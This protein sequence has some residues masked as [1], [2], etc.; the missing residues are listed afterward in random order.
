[1]KNIQRFKLP[2]MIA[3]GLHG[4]LLFS[5]PP[6]PIA[7]VT[8]APPTPVLPPIPKILEMTQPDPA[9]ADAGSGGAGEPVASLPEPVAKLPDQA[10]ITIPSVTRDPLKTLRPDMNTLPRNIGTEGAPWGDPGDGIGK[11]PIFDT[12]SL[13]RTPRAIAQPSPDYPAGLRHEGVTGTVTVEFV[14]NA[15]G[16]VVSAQALRYTHREF[17]EPA[18]RAVLKWRFEPGR[19]HGR[20]V[21][22]RM[23]VPIEFTAGAE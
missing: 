6:G 22:F 1:M 8:A 2:V 21:S 18:V 17:V 23:A 13:D 16:R 19:H 12:R 4:A 7:T 11:P 3:A 15:E 5:L 9:A 20:P 14:V 10:S